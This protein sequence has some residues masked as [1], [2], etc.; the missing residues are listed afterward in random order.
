VKGDYRMAGVPGTG[1]SIALGF[2]QPG[3][4]V[5]GRL[6]PTGRPR[7]LLQTMMGDVEVSIVDAAN[8]LVFVRARDLGLKGWELPVAV[9]SDPDLLARL[10]SVRAAAAVKMGLASDP[11]EATRN[12]PSVPKVAFISPTTDYMMTSGMR[13]PA[14]DIDLVARIMSMGR[15]HST[16]AVTGAICT[17]GATKIA[18]TVMYDMITPESRASSRVRLGHPSGEITVDVEL[19]T[20]TPEPHYVCAT[21]YRTARRIMEG[22]VYVP[23][24]L[25]VS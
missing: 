4:A 1:A 7:D 18:G 8:P 24:S 16:Y 21:V 23:E 25:F 17:A 9:D 3:G 2:E 10:E 19:E 15:L 14:S 6:L 20:G 12:S 11:A 22:F 13:M 5:T